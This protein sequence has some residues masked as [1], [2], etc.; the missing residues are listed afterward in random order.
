MRGYYF[1]TRYLRISRAQAKR[2][3]P[4]LMRYWRSWL[5]LAMVRPMKISR[6][7]STPMTMPLILPMPPTKDTP[8]MT[9]A[10]M[11]SSS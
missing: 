9:Q 4:P 7:I 2:M 5:M 3:M 11:A 6:S 1:L 10:A 8:P